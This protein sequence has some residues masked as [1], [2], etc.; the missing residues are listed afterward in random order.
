MFA[1]VLLGACL[2][3]QAILPAAQGVPS[4]ATLWAKTRNTPL[5]VQGVGALNDMPVDLVTSQM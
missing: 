2:A 5:A 3:V 4:L 1:R